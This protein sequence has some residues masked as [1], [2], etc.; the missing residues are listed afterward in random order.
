MNPKT[1]GKAAKRLLSSVMMVSLL[2]ACSRPE[3]AGGPPGAGQALPVK[4][5]ELDA[6]PV[7]DGSEFVGTLEA[8][9][10]VTLQP[11]TQGRVKEVF[12]ANGDRVTQG[13]PILSLSIDQSQANV[14]TARAG[15][16]SAQASVSAAQAAKGTA[17]AR[18][19]ASQADQARAAAD[20]QLQQTEFS[21]TSALV[22]EG[23]QSQQQLDVARRNLDAARA[24]E[25]AARKQV[26]AAQASVNEAQSG[27]ARAQSGVRE[28]ESR[29]ASQSVEL[30]FRQVVA[31]MTG[32]VG[33]FPVKPGDF[34]TPQTTLTTLTSNDQLDMRISVPSNYSDRMRIGL[35]VQLIDPSTKK[36]LGTGSISFIS[37]QVEAGAQSIL[38][39]ARFQNSGNLRDGQFVQ[40][41]IVWDKTTGILVPTTAITRV[42]GQ[43]FV[44]A[45]EEKPAEGDS[46]AQT[47]VAQR[48]VR[49]GSIQG[50]SYVVLDG[51]KPGDKIATTNILRLRDGAPVQPEAESSPSPSP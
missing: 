43:A 47:I 20:L 29:V 48:P 46:P 23:A 24:A 50:N 9:Q 5:A 13:T 40:S 11:Q 31:P 8:A 30:D 39:K 28:A 51:L 49:L 19:Q 7:E 27:I 45:V 41:R 36:S 17:E 25:A 32:I 4:I 6:S 15:V 21:R 38:T 26:A 35:P 37:P 18:L 44:Y 1:T 12:V 10:K 16:S 2:V 22:A 3:Q 33:S 42:G 34:V 14:D